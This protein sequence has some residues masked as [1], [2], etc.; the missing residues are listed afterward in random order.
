MKPG[1]P[2]CE[3]DHLRSPQHHRTA[4]RQELCPPPP[5]KSYPNCFAADYLTTSLK[6]FQRA[7]ALCSVRSSKSPPIACKPPYSSRMPECFVRQFLR[8]YSASPQ[9]SAPTLHSESTR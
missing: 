1:L 6:S 3:K 4:H 5:A 2:A 7:R 9:R 8:V